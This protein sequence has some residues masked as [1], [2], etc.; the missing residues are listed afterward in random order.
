[1]KYLLLALLVGCSTTPVSET[2]SKFLFPPG[3]YEQRITLTPSAPNRNPQAFGGI[4]SIKKEKIEVVGLSPFGTTVFHIQEELPS[5]KISLNIYV[6]ELKRFENRI[7]DY[8]SVMRKIL[9]APRA[10]NWD[11]G[12]KVE[13]RDER[14]RPTQVFLPMDVAISRYDQVGVPGEISFLTEDHKISVLVKSYEL[15]H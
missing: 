14:G 13:K 12:V 11:A 7:R 4:L 5:K 15:A 8:Y 3:V 9:M 2:T 6:A 10:G 1:M